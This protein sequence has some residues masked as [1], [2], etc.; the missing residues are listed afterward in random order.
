MIVRKIGEGASE[1]DLL[2]AYPGLTPEGIRAALIYAADFLA[3]EG[4]EPA[5]PAR[6]ALAPVAGH[7]DLDLD[8]E[9]VSAALDFFA[10]R[11][12]ERHDFDT[13]VTVSTPGSPDPLYVT[14]M[15]AGGVEFGLDV[16]RGATAPHVIR[17]QMATGLRNFSE[18]DF[19]G[20]ALT[21][22]FEIPPRFMEVLHRA[23]LEMSPS[24][25]V[26]YFLASS[27]GENKRPFVAAE[28][29]AML[30]V[31]RAVIRMDR[32]GRLKP[33]RLRAHRLQKLVLSG[34]P[35]DPDI[36][37]TVDVIGPP[38]RKPPRNL[39]HAP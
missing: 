4:N 19:F 25:E 39:A 28:A 24:D 1:R 6:E 3:H 31:L 5:R 15:G 22:V 37:V 38:S 16:F 34:S 21:P 17:R 11:P 12:W 30:G 27:A 33:R 35:A 29:E 32:D 7:L 18:L 2:D 9:L 8:L 36:E 20:F 13:F 10:Q 23:R 26:P 14:I